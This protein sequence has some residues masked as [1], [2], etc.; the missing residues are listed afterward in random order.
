MK[1]ICLS[2]HLWFLSI[3]LFLKLFLIGLPYHFATFFLFYCYS[4]KLHTKDSEYSPFFYLS[5]GYCYFFYFI[6]KVYYT[7]TNFTV[8]KI[9][10]VFNVNLIEYKYTESSNL[11]YELVISYHNNW[12]VKIDLHCKISFRFS[13]RYLSIEYCFYYLKTHTFSNHT[14]LIISLDIIE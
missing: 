13:L 9:R 2:G 4:S 1:C 7:W 11:Y 5:I 6:F 12:T 8:T 3:D 10:N 14:Q